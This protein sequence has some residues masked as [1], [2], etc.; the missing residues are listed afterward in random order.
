MEESGLIRDLF[1]K[2]KEY[3]MAGSLGE[4][5]EVL[6]ACLALTSGR[7]DRD[8]LIVGLKIELANVLLRKSFH[9]K[10]VD[11]TSLDLLKESLALARQIENVK[12]IGDALQGLGHYYFKLGSENWNE[13]L[14]VLDESLKYRAIAK[15]NYG[16]SRSHFTIGLIHQRRGELEKA[17]T[18]FKAS[19]EY[20]LLTGSKYMEGENQR[21]LGY[22]FYLRNDFRNAMPH[23]L[24]SLRLREAI[25]YTDGA[26]FA[27]I[28]VGQTYLRLDQKAIGI[29]YLERGLDYAIE[30]N[31]PAGMQRAYWT[32]AQVYA[33]DDV[34]EKD[35]ARKM[36]ERTIE[37]ARLLN[38]SAS[39]KNALQLLAKIDN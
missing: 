6:E 5:K 39:E 9:Y 32:L 8:S 13:G 34:K 7:E 27:A 20:A 19:L 38:D 14:E 11:S 4:S 24:N 33:E 22:Q 26:I 21:H 18:Q 25:H 12:L 35:K 28:T 23:F 31:S 10:Q 2:S 29:E 1:K 37:I 36:I 16:F 3:R 17:G 30:M 15:D